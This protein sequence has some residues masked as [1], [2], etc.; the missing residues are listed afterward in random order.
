MVKIWKIF[1][2][3]LRIVA[4]TLHEGQNRFMTLSRPV[5]LRMRNFATKVVEKI[6]RQNTYLHNNFFFQRLV[7]KI[8]WTNVVEPERPQMKIWR[9]LFACWIQKA[10]FT[11]YV[12][13][14]LLSA[15]TVI[16][17]TPLMLHCMQIIRLVN[18]C[19]EGK[20]LCE[21]TLRLFWLHRKRPQYP[22]GTA[23]FVRLSQL[24]DLGI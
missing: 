19:N 16:A 9:M 2:W 5:L 7:Y 15:A 13:W 23:C 1:F 11:R 22:L 18:L 12:S 3:N 6:K 24:F 20:W 8:V 17:R 4:G 10:T 21:F 14:L